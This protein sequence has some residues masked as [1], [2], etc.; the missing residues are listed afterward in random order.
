MIAAALRPYGEML[1]PTMY[2]G[3]ASGI[4]M[5]S[6]QLSSELEK[7]A[8]MM[9][10]LVKV[11]NRGGYFRQ[12]HMVDAVT[13]AVRESG[14]QS[15]FEAAAAVELGKTAEDAY[16]LAAYKVRVMMSHIRRKFD[17]RKG[18]AGSTTT[19]TIF[20]EIFTVMAEGDK[21][22]IPDTKRRRTARLGGAPRPHPFLNF[23][24]DDPADGPD[25]NDDVDDADDDGNTSTGQVEVVMRFFDRVHKAARLLKSDG[26][27]W[28]ADEY[29]QGDDGF[30]IAKWFE[31]NSTLALETP[32]S[33]Y[34]GDAQI[35][36]TEPQPIT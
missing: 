7:Y 32:N 28:N 20:D 36:G 15:A 21:N 8:A 18:Q 6:G 4:D 14:H 1:H 10:A 9:C 31:D 29:H 16:K 24:S 2:G 13:Q 33:K 19:N 17:N 5:Q 35:D 34:Y 25:A 12:A 30:L 27:L 3:V 26:T 22:P 11:D 23:R